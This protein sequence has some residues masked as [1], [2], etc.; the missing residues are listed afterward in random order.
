MKCCSARSR[1]FFSLGLLLLNFF[2][3]SVTQAATDVTNREV[4][5]TFA[6]FHFTQKDYPSAR[7]SI[8]EHLKEDKRD[9]NG[10]NLLG[11]TYLFTGDLVKASKALA[12]AV[13]IAAGQD[14]GIYLYNYADALN[15]QGDSKKAR[16]VLNR[17][18]QFERV[19][20][21][22]K[23]ALKN[24]VSQQPLPELILDQPSAWRSNLSLS[25]GYDSNVLLYSSDTLS[26]TDS[27]GTASPVFSLLAQLSRK[28]D[29]FGGELNWNNGVS[30]A[31]HTTDE[32][33]AYNALAGTIGLDWAAP[34][35][36][37]SAG[38]WGL[39][40]D[41]SIS[42]LNLNDSFGFFNWKEQPYVRFN[43]QHNKSWSSRVKVP[44][45]YQKFV[46]EATDEAVDDRSGVGLKPE[47]VSTV[48]SGKNIFTAG[49]QFEQIFT[50]GS[51]YQSTA[52]GIPLSWSRR[53]LK[54]YFGSL[55]VE[56][57]MLNF[58][59]SST[60][61]KD[62]LVKA[63]LG[64]SRRFSEKWFGSLNYLFTRNFSSV[65][66]ADYSKHAGTLVLNYGIF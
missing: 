43:F 54:N 1:W 29:A 9:A 38:S 40:N 61:R 57:V 7:E 53:V 13:K 47:I 23:G 28:S 65:A 2:A 6:Q 51:N 27:T 48:L 26:F 3:N 49:L 20:V 60:L 10:W 12:N 45:F 52:V 63:G 59:R 34:G 62:T 44:I 5:L 56:G 42:F 33:N 41:L 19:E 11:L 32:A 18:T 39:G 58:P 30:F 4:A 46:V 8:I 16:L 35:N 15:R 37:V 55:R 24:L 31:Y 66:S 36:G 50:N 21:A 17:A 22:S 14:K 64:L 25:S